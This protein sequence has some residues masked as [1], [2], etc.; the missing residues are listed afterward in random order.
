MKKHISI[1]LAIALL[2]GW[3]ACRKD[4][5]LNVSSKK[6]LEE[7]LE[8]EVARRNLTSIA[9]C[10]VKND[11]L[12]YSS[13]QGFADEDANVLATD[14]TRY[15]IASVSK[16]I[17]AVALMQLVEQNL[18]ALDD[19]VD[20]FLPFSVRNP[21][22]PND[23]ITCRMLL[24]HTSSISDAFQDTQDLD[25]YGA[26]CPM[27]LAQFFENVFTPS[28]SYFSP[29][30][31]S[32]HSPGTQEDYSN[33]ASALLGYLVERI[34]A[35]PFDQYC[36]DHIFT[37]LGMHK[38][39]WRLANTPISE[40]AIPY[41]PD[42]TDPNPHYTF[43][44]YPNGGL[45]TT[46]LDLSAFLRAIIQNGTFNGTQ[47]LSTASMATMK[48][49]QFGSTEQC[50]SFYYETINGKRLLGHNGGEKGVSAEMYY[51]PT[52]NVG[53]IVFNNDDD[54]ELGNVIS[55][56]LSYGEKL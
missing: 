19:D 11:A 30:N 46:V 26:D 40:L 43:P 14:S 13:A 56:L 55:L 4:D 7:K 27:T 20:D 1:V 45:R 38:T 44:D 49:L 31:F 2:C 48:T 25:C 16:T 37:P 15:L 21:S 18:I 12:L 24:S 22:F 28:G 29:D 47:I 36:D 54:A 5:D 33:L 34:S 17:T 23:K 39:E 6:E 8:A 10:V 41:S 53:A 51:D 32:E 52:T 9:Y 35:T 42:I 50:L 3:T